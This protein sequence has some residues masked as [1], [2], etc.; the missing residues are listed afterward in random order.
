MMEGWDYYN[1]VINYQEIYYIN[2]T[3][4]LNIMIDIWHVIQ[5]IILGN[6]FYQILPMVHKVTHSCI[7]AHRFK[8]SKLNHVVFSDYRWLPWTTKMKVSLQ[9][10]FHIC[11]WHWCFTFIQKVFATIHSLLV[12]QQE[13]LVSFSHN[14]FTLYMGLLMI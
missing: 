2:P 13:L 8:K 6:L 14:V 3:E 9:T 5:E 11:L 1:G 10:K 7:L 4:N 12:C